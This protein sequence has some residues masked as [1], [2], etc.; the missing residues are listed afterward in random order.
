[1]LTNLKRDTM[2]FAACL[3]LVLSGCGG[4][5]NA[6]ETVPLTPLTPSQPAPSEAGLTEITISGVVA[7]GAPCSGAPVTFS[8]F[9]I[10]KVPVVATAADGSYTTSIS[11]TT[12][13][14]AKPIFVRAECPN[15]AGGNDT[16]VSVAPTS[17]GGTVKVN[18]LL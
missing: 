5:N 12:K 14:V 1:M 6:T 9:S 16:L 18:P 10:A 2:K 4:S 3:L 17:A 13:E 15:A 7:T 11:V 8:G